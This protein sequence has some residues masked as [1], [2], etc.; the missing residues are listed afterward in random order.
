M[1]LDSSDFNKI[2][3]YLDSDLIFDIYL[4]FVMPNAYLLVV[5]ILF[6]DHV[7]QGACIVNLSLHLGHMHLDVD[8]C[9]RSG[10]AWYGH[11]VHLR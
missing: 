9:F 7:S 3:A 5:N 8:F 2:C 1:C 4:V 6:G 10:A 11:S